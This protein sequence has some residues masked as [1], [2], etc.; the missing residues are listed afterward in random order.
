MF[1]GHALSNLDDK[2]RLILPAKFRKFISPDADNKVI[3]TKGFD[4]CLLLYP[5]NEWDIVIKGVS[6]YNQFN[7]EQRNFI[8]EFLMHVNECELDS[9]NRILIPPQ[10]ST[11]A[12]IKKQVLVLGLIDKIELW[13]PEVK[14]KYTSSMKKSYEEIAEKISEMNGL[15][16]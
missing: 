8:R 14:E 13:D 12:K 10:L 4:E 11:F 3:I 1:Q 5:K 7:P 2:S 9:Q 6:R 15:R 16:L